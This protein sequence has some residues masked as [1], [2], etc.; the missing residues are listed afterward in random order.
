M[1]SIWVIR[2]FHEYLDDCDVIIMSATDEPP[3]LGSTG[4]YT[5]TNQH[6]KKIITR[7]KLESCLLHN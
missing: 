5:G 6:V 1:Q 2:T 7:K 4:K 3:A